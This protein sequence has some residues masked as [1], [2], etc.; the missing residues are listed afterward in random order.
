MVYCHTEEEG[1]SVPPYNIPHFIGIFTKRVPHAVTSVCHWLMYSPISP[2]VVV[3]IV[4]LFL[5]FD[6]VLF[7]CSYIYEC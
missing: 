1:D 7:H 4:V 2:I 6:S 5:F 3:L